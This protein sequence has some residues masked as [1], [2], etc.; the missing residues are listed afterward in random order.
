MDNN[1]IREIITRSNLADP[2]NNNGSILRRLM[3]ENAVNDET[4]RQDIKTHMDTYG[5][6]LNLIGMN[7]RQ[8]HQYLHFVV[9][10]TKNEETIV[11]REILSNITVNEDASIPVNTEVILE[12][13][14]TFVDIG[15]NLSNKLLNNINS[16]KISRKIANFKDS[17]NSMNNE[18]TLKLIKTSV[19]L[20]NQDPSEIRESEMFKRYTKELANQIYTPENVNVVGLLVDFSNVN[21]LLTYLA[22][23]P[24]IGVLIGLR[25]LVKV[26]YTLH[27]T[28]TFKVF[29]ADIYKNLLDKKGLPLHII[30]PEIWRN[31]KVFVWEYKYQ[32]ISL[33]ITT[34]LMV[35]RIYHEQ[36]PMPVIP[37]IPTLENRYIL[38]TNSD[39][40]KS[41][42]YVKELGA[43]FVF[44]ACS[45]IREWNDAA[46]AGLYGDTVS[47]WWKDFK[48]LAKEINREISNSKIAVPEAKDIKK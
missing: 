34:T 36:L 42:K 8:K 38:D 20:S 16:T 23:C 13:A 21:E 26:Y 18:T 9:Q 5:D 33:G 6:T 41:Y 12:K 11:T 43:Q 37:V 29:L 7:Q 10:K 2:S 40:Y 15:L 22:V 44:M 27:Q 25:K 46:C 28:G 39:T 1:R 4:I 45:I 32:I 35:Y 19:N 30:I 24:S 3:Q 47:N 48:E 14:E 31:T 17:A